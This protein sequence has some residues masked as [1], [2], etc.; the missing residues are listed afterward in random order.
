MSLLSQS[1]LTIPV[2]CAVNRE[3]TDGWPDKRMDG[4]LKSVYACRYHIQHVCMYVCCMLLFKLGSAYL[5]CFCKYVD[6]VVVVVVLLVLVVYLFI[7]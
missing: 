5:V 2:N 7:F 3:Q 6:G 4:R 1:Q